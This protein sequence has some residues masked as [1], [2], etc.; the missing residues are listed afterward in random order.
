MRKNKLSVCLVSLGSVV[1][2]GDFNAITGT[3]RDGYVSCAGSH[4][5][6]SSIESSSV[7]LDLVILALSVKLLVESM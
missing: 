1:I 7:L 4:R 2:L 5:F 3:D 6:G